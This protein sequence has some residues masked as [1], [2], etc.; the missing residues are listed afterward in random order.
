[1]RPVVNVHIH[2][3]EINLRNLLPH[4]V[5]ENAKKNQ[6]VKQSAGPYG[7]QI[8]RQC[9]HRRR[10]HN[11]RAGCFL[12]FVDDSLIHRHIKFSF[13]SEAEPRAHDDAYF[14]TSSF[15]VVRKDVAGFSCECKNFFFQFFP[16]AVFS[17]QRFGNG[18]F[19]DPQ[20]I[21]QVLHGY[22]FSLCHVVNSLSI[23]FLTYS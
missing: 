10:N 20:L 5:V 13:I 19:T 14:F 8:R 16:H 6:T 4:P 3:R 15:S 11:A 9:C 22:R 23:C 17:I 7:V 2:L 1:M 18:Y 21:R 12:Q